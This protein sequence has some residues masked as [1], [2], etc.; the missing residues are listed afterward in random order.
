M[1]QTIIELTSLP[2]AKVGDEV[3]IISADGSAPN[4]V[5]SLASL[6]GTINYEIMCRLGPRVRRVAV[7]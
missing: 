4:S 5:E 6:A 2:G 7:A 1:D 3:E